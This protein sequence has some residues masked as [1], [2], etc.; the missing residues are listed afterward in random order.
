MII[1]RMENKDIEELTLNSKNSLGEEI[2]Y[3]ITYFKD[4]EKL[5]SIALNGFKVDNN[6][7][8][9]LNCLKKLK[10]II[11]NHCKFVNDD[12]L[13]NNIENTIITYSNIANINI[14]EKLDKLKTIELMGI[15][16]VYINNFIEM[17]NLAELS[18]YNSKIRNS[19]LINDFINLKK[20][21]LDGSLVDEE[22]F[23][24]MLNK[25]VEFSYNDKYFLES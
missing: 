18:I 14:F 11:F 4:L 2:Q 20:L 6:L 8:E 16:E 10:T 23:S 24:E 15:D 5:E 22:K 9:K 7:I 12:K 25:S 17:K 21:K 1:A 3:N 19:I 13:A